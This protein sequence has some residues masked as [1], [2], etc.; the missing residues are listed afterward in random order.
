MK[1]SWLENIPVKLGREIVSDRKRLQKC[2]L[3]IHPNKTFLVGLAQ[4]EKVDQHN[5][6]ARADRLK[7]T[8]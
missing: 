6:L 3:G 7:N 1:T 8:I 2:F 5:P 4:G